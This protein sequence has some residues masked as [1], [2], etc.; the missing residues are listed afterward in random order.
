MPI[1]FEIVTCLARVLTDVLYLRDKCI[2]ID[3]IDD[4]WCVVV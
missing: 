2:T 3:A 1:T 4:I